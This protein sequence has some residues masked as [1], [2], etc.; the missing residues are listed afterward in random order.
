MSQADLGAV[1]VCPEC[2]AQNIPLA[3]QCWMCRGDLKLVA[4]VEVVTAEV[5]SA[6]PKFAPSAAFFPMLTVLAIVVAVLVGWALGEQSLGI[7]P[8]YAIIVIP[9]LV[10]AS[11]RVGRKR[12]AGQ[13]VSWG[14]AILTGVIAAAVVH[15]AL[16][17]LAIAGLVALF[18]FCVFNPPSFH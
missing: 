12:L 8:F 5:V 17:L 6:A 11:V 3:R 18:A 4:P 15:G 14:E 13:P 2:G 10:A 1:K 16:G 7:L 9:A